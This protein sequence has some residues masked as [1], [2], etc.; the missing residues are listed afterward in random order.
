MDYEKLPGSGASKQ[1]KPMMN[2][3]A[4]HHSNEHFLASLCC[5]CYLLQ[6]LLILHPE[7]VR[8]RGAARSAFLKAILLALVEK[9]GLRAA[10]VD[11]LWTAIA[12]FLQ[13]R[14]LP[15]VVGIRDTG[16][17]ADDASTLVRAVVALVADTHQSAWANVR[18]TDNTLAIVSLAQAADRHAR[19]LTAHDQIRVVLRH[20]CLIR[21]LKN[22]MYMRLGS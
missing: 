17:T 1:T 5:S 3:T 8:H 12:I 13:L 21:Y 14:T 2:L 19:L 4:K 18:V 9:I 7:S 10:Q 22:S 11:D 16:S 15:T 20:G 6:T